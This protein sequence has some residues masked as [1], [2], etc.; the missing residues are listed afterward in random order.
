MSLRGIPGSRRYWVTKPNY[1][2]TCY[3][4]GWS[5]E[6]ANAKGNA[7]RHHDRTGHKVAVE[8]TRSIVYT[9]EARYAEDFPNG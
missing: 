4:C 9:T 5:A 7:A 1:L 2:V 8:E 6:G 3:D